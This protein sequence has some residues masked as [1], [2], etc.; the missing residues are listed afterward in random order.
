M[1]GGEDDMRDPGLRGAR[2]EPP[3]Q[4]HDGFRALRAESFLGGELPREEALELLGLHQPPERLAQRLRWFLL[5]RLEGGLQPAAAIGPVDMRGLDRQRAAIAPRQCRGGQPGRL[6]MRREGAGR[7]RRR[8]R[9]QWIGRGKQVAM[10]P[11][12]LAQQ[13]FRIRRRRPGLELVEH[14]EQHAPPD[15]HGV[16]PVAVAFP[17]CLDPAGI[18]GRQRRCRRPHPAIPSLLARQLRA[19]LAAPRRKHPHAASL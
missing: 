10:R 13:R 17:Q 1:H 14:V 19:S 8:L 7:G 11:D 5:Q 12:G 18:H 15:F 3:Q 9:R 6:H 16:R 2:Q 4:R